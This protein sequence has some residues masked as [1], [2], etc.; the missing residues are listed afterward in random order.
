M[1]QECNSLHQC[2]NTVSSAQLLYRPVFNT[3]PSTLHCG[4][5][6]GNEAKFVQYHAPYQ[7]LAFSCVKKSYLGINITEVTILG[8]IYNQEYY[9][10]LSFAETGSQSQVKK[11]SHGQLEYIMVT[12]KSPLAIRVCNCL[13]QHSCILTS[14]V[15]V[16]ILLV[17]VQLCSSVNYSVH[18]S[19]LLL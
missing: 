19:Q 7:E 9:D 12:V 3:T 1:Q 13:R 2:L 16:I 11:S 6:S 14:Q 5:G 15:R 18:S 4:N 8:L 17:V 10:H